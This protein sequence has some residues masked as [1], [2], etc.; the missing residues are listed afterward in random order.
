M[1]SLEKG[2]SAVLVFIALKLGAA[3]IG[4]L[5]F[6][7]HW[8]LDPMASLGIVLVFLAAGVAASVVFPGKER[9]A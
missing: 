8:T 6:G 5:A 9:A 1:T 4:E 3:A 7:A 2:G